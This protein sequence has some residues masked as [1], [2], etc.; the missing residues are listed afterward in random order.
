MY[1]NSILDLDVPKEDV[2]LT[3]TWDV[4]KLE[5]YSLQ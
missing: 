5:Q 2:R 3:L 1:L 4:F